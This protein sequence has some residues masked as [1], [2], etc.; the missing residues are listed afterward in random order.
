MLLRAA[1]ATRSGYANASARAIRRC[2]AAAAQEA[3]RQFPAR[4][5]ADSR[6]VDAAFAAT[7]VRAGA[8]HG[9]AP[10]EVALPSPYGVRPGVA[11]LL[12]RGAC[13]AVIQASS[14]QCSLE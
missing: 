5:L 14:S 7:V 13:P 1:D 10:L 4:A 2:A 9:L 6:G 11:A 12:Q 8:P 3:E